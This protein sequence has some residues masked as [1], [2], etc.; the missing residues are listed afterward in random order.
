MR[1]WSKL[2]ETI[3][4]SKVELYTTVVETDGWIEDNQASY[5]SSLTYSSNFDIA[6]KT[7]IFCA[8]AAARVSIAFAQQLFG[9]VD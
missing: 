8:V 7:L 9:E 2:W 6:Q 5:N 1:Y 4:A 3:D